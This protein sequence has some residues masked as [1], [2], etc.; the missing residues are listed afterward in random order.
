MLAKAEETK[1]AAENMGGKRAEEHCSGRNSIKGKE[2]GMEEEG[3][4]R[5]VRHLVSRL[6]RGVLWGP[7]LSHPLARQPTSCAHTGR[8]EVA[9][10]RGSGS[11]DTH[12]NGEKV[13]LPFLTG[14]AK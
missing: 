11:G 8:K 10:P 3:K 4:E 13:Y 12:L 7:W 14:Y 5:E 6:S 9:S 1:Q 2:E